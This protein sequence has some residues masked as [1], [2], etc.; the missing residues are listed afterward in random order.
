MC[1][2][3][4]SVRSL[5]PL[6]WNFTSYYINQGQMIDCVSIQG[7]D[8]GL[9]AHQVLGADCP[10]LPLVQ[11]IGSGSAPIPSWADHPSR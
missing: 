11:N 6:I 7:N 5:K 2:I 10:S 3:Q 9:E 1:N 8:S 4:I